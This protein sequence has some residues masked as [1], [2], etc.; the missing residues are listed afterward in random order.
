MRITLV[1]VLLCACSKSSSVDCEALKDKYLTLTEAKMRGAL[2]GI[3]PGPNKDAIVAQ[4]EKELGMAR[5]RF[6]GVCKELGAMVD[7]SCFEQAVDTDK[8]RKQRC[9]DLKKELDHKL[10]RSP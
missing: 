10:Y 2:G 4:G 7:P 9:H 5:E 1:V 6:V 8:E 3:E